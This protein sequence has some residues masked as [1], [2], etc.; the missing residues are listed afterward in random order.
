MGGQSWEQEVPGAGP[1]A[2]RSGR[3]IWEVLRSPAL[4]ATLSSRGLRRDPG[5]SSTEGHFCHKKPLPWQSS[6][7]PAVVPSRHVPVPAVSFWGRARAA[8]PGATGPPRFT[9]RCPGR[10]DRGGRTFQPQ[11]LQ[12]GSW[13]Q[14]AP[15]GPTCSWNSGCR[16]PWR[17][18]PATRLGILAVSPHGVC[19]MAGVGRVLCGDL[20]HAEAI[21]DP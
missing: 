13:G 14:R 20:C 12:R 3:E 9:L 21:M 6:R 5:H 8:G 11:R 15:R 1:R 18:S 17:Q 2:R 7:S 4:E 19:R 16:G 10:R